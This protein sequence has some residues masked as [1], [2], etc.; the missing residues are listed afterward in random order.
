MQLGIVQ[1]SCSC[2]PVRC[3]TAVNAQ[4]H[5]QG[6]RG[7][8]LSL[9]FYDGSSSRA[10]GIPLRVAQPLCPRRICRTPVQAVAAP[11]QPATTILVAEKLGAPGLELL[12]KYGRVETAYGMKH[13]ELLK[14]V[15][16]GVDALIVRSATKVT[17]DVFEAA[18]GGL[19]VVGRAGVGVDNVDLDAAT[20]FG[21]LVVN[22]PTANT[23]AAAEHAIAL[24]ASMAR[25][26]PQADLSVKEG[27][28]E[29]T[30]YVGVSL[31]NKT[32]AIIGFGKVGGEV[33][34]RANGLGMNVLAY[35]P[36]ASEAK[37]AAFGVRLVSFDEALASSD[38]LSLHMPMTPDTKGMFNDAAFAKMKKGVRIMNVARGGVIDDDSLVRALD[39]K[40]VAQVA[41][42][43]FEEEPPS[44]DNP[45][46]HRPDVVCTPHLGAS[47]V[48]AQEDVAVEIAD[49]VID[50]LKGELAATAVNAPMVP[51]EILAEL[52]P[53]V[54]LAQG[55]GRAAV[56]LVEAGGFTDV[57]VEYVSPRGDEL[58]TRLLRAMV[59][60]GMLE[61][62]T[63]SNINLVNADLVA[64]A[65][66][67]RVIESIL[68]ADGKEV[69]T[70]MRVRLSTS[71]TR[72]SA[73]LSKEG[74]ISVT[75]AVKGRSPF[76]TA[77]GEFDV[78]LAM[79]G[80]VLLVRQTDR[81]GIIAAVSAVLGSGQVNISF[82]TV[83]RTGRGQDAIMAIG[84][85]ERPNEHLLEGIPHIPGISEFAVL[86]EERVGLKA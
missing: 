82:M 58:D 32:I 51:A 55:L 7:A 23:V 86:S 47:T 85:D 36:Y 31:V 26:V 67:I 12:E 39:A 8:Q 29:R 73:A 28:W 68:P 35:D 81:P 50:A 84:V 45:L 16:S 34:R 6:S 24:M 5:L 10:F 65:R 75:G 11:D 72:F 9:K 46:I 69:L 74:Q 38:F 43:V 60:K 56:Q 25:N 40:I 18:N 78:E 20:E 76:L 21:C 52:Q 62:I 64:K 77:V 70:S 49:A 33:A 4:R 71:N 57:F 15:A 41:L 79:E 3:P 63:T 17:R 61:Q 19:K 42:D 27:K 30:K 83:C 80:I 13:D 54:S 66:G 2:R 1:P 44:K 37:A 59:L 48:E 53:F 22:A 14:K